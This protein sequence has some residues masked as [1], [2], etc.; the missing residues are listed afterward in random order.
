MK[1][2]H[3]NLLFSLLLAFITSFLLLL[4][5]SHPQE[6]GSGTW[7]PGLPHL[8]THVCLAQFGM[9]GLE[10]VCFKCLLNKKCHPSLH[11]IN[12]APTLTWS[13]W[14]INFGCSFLLCLLLLLLAMRSHPK[15]TVT[16][17]LQPDKV[18]WQEQAD[19]HSWIPFLNKVL[20]SPKRYSG[21]LAKSCLSK[22]K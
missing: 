17:L 9:S 1:R 22:T 20:Y 4:S 2:F 13:C 16:N 12:I 7:G 19:T 14:V 8:P 11:N 18:G 3:S 21:H 5:F 15:L 6:A 10:I